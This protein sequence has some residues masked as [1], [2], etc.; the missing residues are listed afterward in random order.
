MKWANNG[1]NLPIPIWFCMTTANTQM[2]S[3]TPSFEQTQF[4]F[5]RQV[6]LFDKRIESSENKSKI[7]LRNK[8]NGSNSAPAN[9]HNVKMF[10]VRDEL[11]SRKTK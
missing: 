6:K 3:R 11:K 1:C 7:E 5:F 9:D 2:E 8:V 4:L 10:H